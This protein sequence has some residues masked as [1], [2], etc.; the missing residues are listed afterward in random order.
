MVQ[1][2]G[3]AFLSLDDKES[4]ASASVQEQIPH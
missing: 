1:E 4:S 2:S 3:E